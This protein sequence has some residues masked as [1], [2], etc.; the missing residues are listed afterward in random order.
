MFVAT[1]VGCTCSPRKKDGLYLEPAQ[2]NNLAPGDTNRK[3]PEQ[4][5][6]LRKM[7]R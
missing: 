3:E 6:H 2:I 1:G 7:R 4:N 5:E